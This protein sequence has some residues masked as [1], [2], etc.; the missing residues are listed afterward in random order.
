VVARAQSE[1]IKMV[2]ADELQAA[3]GTAR[4]RP[5]VVDF[6]ATWCGPCLLLATELEK[7]G[8]AACCWCALMP[9][10]HAYA[11]IRFKQEAFMHACLSIWLSCSS[12]AVGLHMLC[13]RTSTPRRFDCATFKCLA[14]THVW[15]C[16]MLA[17]VAAELGDGVDIYKLDVDAKDNQELS[18]GLQVSTGLIAGD[19]CSC[20]VSARPA[21]V[22]VY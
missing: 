19:L 12:W 17:Q 21:A 20:C 5:I 10:V 14:C 4:E 6:F 13:S 2:N 18:T 9:V 15:V 8:T 7:V 11:Q 16:C 1:R 22:F 3:I